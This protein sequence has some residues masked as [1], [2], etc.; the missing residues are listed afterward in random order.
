MSARRWLITYLWCNKEVL[1]CI[2]FTSS[3]YNHFKHSPL[4]DRVHSLNNDNHNEYT[5]VDCK[6]QE[7]PRKRK[8]T[9]PDWFHRRLWTDT[10][11]APAEPSGT[12]WWRRFSRRRSGGAA[13]ARATACCCETWRGFEFRIYRSPPVNG[14][15]LTGYGWLQQFPIAIWK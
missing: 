2:F 9:T 10:D 15:A 1:R 3:I 12:T 7:S 8:S 6:L 14:T 11:S 13:S 5:E 4:I